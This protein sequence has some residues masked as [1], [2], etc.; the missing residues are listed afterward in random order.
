M[1][2]YRE[3]CYLCL[4]SLSLHL[5]NWFFTGVA[6]LLLSGKAKPMRKIAWPCKSY[7]Q[8]FLWKVT[9]FSSFCVSRNKTFQ[10]F[11]WVLPESGEGGPEGSRRGIHYHCSKAVLYHQP[12]CFPLSL[13]SS[14][15]PA[16]S[17]THCSSSTSS[18]CQTCRAKIALATHKTLRNGT[19]AKE[20]LSFYRPS[21]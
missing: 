5:Y 14:C 8:L 17:I 15:S 21:P 19:Q 7:H 2:A 18:A 9:T 3:W 11:L 13:S 12:P 10:C 1:Y 4:P 16:F 20:C 6:E